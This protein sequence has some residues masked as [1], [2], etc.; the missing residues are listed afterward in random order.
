ME[1]LRFDLKF[2]KYIFLSEL[3]L[4]FVLLYFFTATF[5]QLITMNNE[6]GVLCAGSDPRAD[7]CA[8]PAT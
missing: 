4:I 5:V 7:G 1:E 3:F 2:C 8:V 6:T